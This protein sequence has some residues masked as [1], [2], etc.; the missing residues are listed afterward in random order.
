MH[1]Q[2]LN[3]QTL[4]KSVY[5]DAAIKQTKQEIL[6]IET[7]QEV[8]GTLGRKRLELVQNCLKDADYWKA[9]T[10][11]EKINIYKQLVDGIVILNGEILEINLLF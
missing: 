6:R 8:E 1:D 10:E 11:E 4:P 3:S 9:I 7:E 2:L 5:I